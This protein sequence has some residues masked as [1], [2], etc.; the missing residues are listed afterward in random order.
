MDIST[1]KQVPRRHYLALTGAVLTGSLA[2]CSGGREPATVE[3]S[4]TASDGDTTVQ[5]WEGDQ[6]TLEPGEYYFWEL[7]LDWEHEIEYRVDVLEGGP[8]DVHIMTDAELQ[9]LQ[10]GEEFTVIEAATW[11]DVQSASDTVTLDEGE[12][13]IVAINAD[14][15]PENV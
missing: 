15:Q 7:T 10:D 11:Q 2:G 3:L 9:K 1:A 12:Y 4:V 13:W 8:I 5:V 6:A 14:M